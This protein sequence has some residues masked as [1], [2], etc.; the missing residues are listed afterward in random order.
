MKILFGTF[1]TNPA[2]KYSLYGF[3]VYNY[4]KGVPK[5]ARTTVE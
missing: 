2:I 5:D 4:L 1:A 3:F